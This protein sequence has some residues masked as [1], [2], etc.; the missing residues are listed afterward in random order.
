MFKGYSNN[1]DLKRVADLKNKV[2]VLFQ[3]SSVLNLLFSDDKHC[4]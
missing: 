4:Q 1:R 2:C 3:K